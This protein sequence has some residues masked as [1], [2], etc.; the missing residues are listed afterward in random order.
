M[1]LIRRNW[2]TYFGGAL[3]VYLFADYYYF[4]FNFKKKTLSDFSN[5]IVAISSIFFTTSSIFFLIYNLIIQREALQIQHED[6]QTSKEELQQNNITFKKQQESL[7]LQ[8]AE[9]TF[10]NLINFHRNLVADIITQYPDRFF[11]NLKTELYETSLNFHSDIIRAKFMSVSDLHN[12]PYHYIT[13]IKNINEI[14]SFIKSVYEI[15]VFIETKLN[16]D[17]FYHNFLFNILSSD[18]KFIFGYIFHFEL[19]ELEKIKISDELYESAY[20]EDHDVYKISDGYF[21]EIMI[22]EPTQSEFFP[23]EDSSKY[24]HTLWL[25]NQFIEGE[26][27]YMGYYCEI[28]GENYNW[29]EN[30]NEILTKRLIM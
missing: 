10:F 21:P 17:N 24:C 6:L 19:L 7:S 16:N 11:K 28:K 29:I 15:A 12:C 14:E 9:T 23:L 4:S 2:L 26:I 27:K 25:T 18:Q 3:I 30:Y 8:Q 1:V 20:I 5:F 22:Q 13:T